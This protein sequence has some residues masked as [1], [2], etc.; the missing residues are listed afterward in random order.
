MTLKLGN[1]E[2]SDRDAA[3]QL[4]RLLCA[5][6]DFVADTSGEVRSR[7]PEFCSRAVESQPACRCICDALAAPRTITIVIREDL[8]SF[9]G[10]RTDDDVPDDTSN[11]KGSNE[12]VNVENR[13]RWHV[14]DSRGNWVDDP[15]WVILA[16]ELCGHAV[17]GA[18]GRH[19]EWRP[20]KKGYDPNWHG[21][22]FEAEDAIRKAAGLPGL[23]EH[24]PS[25]K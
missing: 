14:R 13:N 24:W 6:A 4:L 12:T 23:G 1:S 25:I 5:E 18:L 7:D 15:D 10:G 20:T 21:R 19:P 17:P 22:A 9:G 16:H 3:L 11:G 8:E 2:P